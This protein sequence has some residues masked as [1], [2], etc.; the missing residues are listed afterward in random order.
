MSILY[1]R[2]C[3]VDVSGEALF[4]QVT[5]AVE[6]GE[7]VGLVGPNGAGKTTLLRACLGELR[8]ESGDVFLTGTLG[9]LPQNPLIDENGTVWSSMLEERAD[10]IDMR[11]QLHILEERM[12]Q[13]TDEKI[14][15]QYSSLTERF[16]TMGGYALEAQIR[17][18]LSGLGLTKEVNRSIQHLSGGQKT[19]LA[20]SKLLLRSPDFL[21][22][23]EPTNH[24]D[25]DA[26]EW[27]EGFLKGYAGAILVVSHDRYFLDNIVQ[28]VLHLE[29]GSLQSYSGNYSEYELQ[30]ALDEM[31][32]AREA[33]KL[34]KKIARLEEYIR[35]NKAGQNSKQARGR[36]TQLN[37]IKPIEV[38]KTAKAMHISLSTGRRSGDR[39]LIL[40][41][42]S[43]EFPGRKLF[44]GVDVE[45]RRGDRVA[46]LGENGVG[47]TSLLKAIKGG[48][49]YKGEIR[50]GANVKLGYYSQEH[51]ELRGKGSILDEIREDSDLLDPEIRSLLAR[52]G[53]VAEEVFKPVSVLS[54]GEKSRLALAKLF[55]T[56]GN[57]LLLDEPTNHLDTRMR[58]VLEE[59][60]QD[61]DGTLLVVSHDRY[62]LD[63][64][65]N[66]IARLT[67]E[68]IR[69]YE[70]DYSTYK[71]QVQEETA[72][73]AQARNVSDQNNSNSVI[74]S[75][76]DNA[77]G[78][79]ERDL[80][81]RQK[82]ALELETQVAE[83]EKEI[84]SL[85][86][87][88]EEVA[89]NYEKAMEIHHAYEE[90]K[91]LLDSTMLEWLELTED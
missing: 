35:R 86:S 48:L 19:R 37:K 3:G 67:P 72:V 77:K 45:L 23:D 73:A 42:V 81:R 26:L 60:L 34:S 61:F 16:E 28:K 88:M 31:T 14:F 39:T 30:R 90:K 22:L 64:V 13:S 68:G 79:T 87:Q 58:D 18:I 40:E 38:S 7:K 89:S 63:R 20:L 32:L 17:K 91:A 78:A 74:P 65:V 83:L 46:L 29:N 5:F 50:L 55:L 11:A 62:F 41:E 69:L 33:D 47:K 75:L 84:N 51:E 25:M 43:I 71:A 85:E 54:G 56:Q 80:K 52:F 9:Y 4:R 1:C 10:L 66:K 21:V 59:A 15:E 24:L 76:K 12:A 8:L 27:L 82:K 57:V 2:N 44:Q 36:E 70:G 6:K 53:F 49:N